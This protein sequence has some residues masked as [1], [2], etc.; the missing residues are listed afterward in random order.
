MA[1][2][3]Q[4]RAFFNRVGQSDFKLACEVYQA[5]TSGQEIT[6]EVRG[7]IRRALRL[8]KGTVPHTACVTQAQ[9]T[10]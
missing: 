3:A 10:A 1:L 5:L 8:A 2:S 9:L 4:S 6:P 7:L